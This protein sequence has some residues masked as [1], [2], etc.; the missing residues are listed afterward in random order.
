M[1]G[2]ISHVTDK[3]IVGMRDTE[4]LSCRSSEIDREHNKHERVTR[5]SSMSKMWSD[6]AH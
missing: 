3:K 2:K 4:F 5:R 6:T 1:G